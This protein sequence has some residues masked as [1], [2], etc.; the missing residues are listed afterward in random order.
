MGKNQIEDV[1]SLASL[2]N[3]SWLCVNENQITSIEPLKHLP[4]LE[5]LGIEGNPIEDM[6]TLAQ[7][8]AL[9]QVDITDQY[10]NPTRLYEWEIEEIAEE[11]K[12]LIK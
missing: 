11:N 5:Q 8:P 6:S 12:C 1:T 7:F 4:C 10:G 2:P 3:L 9:E